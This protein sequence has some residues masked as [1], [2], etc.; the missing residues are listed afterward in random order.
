M[1]YLLNKCIPRD[2]FVFPPVSPWWIC[3]LVWGDV[4][5]SVHGAKCR[6]HLHS[7]QQTELKLGSKAL[8]WAPDACL[9][10]S[11]A[12]WHAVWIG[13]ISEWLSCSLLHTKA[14][15]K[16]ARSSLGT[17]ANKVKLLPEGAVRKQFLQAV[18]CSCLFSQ[19]YDPHCH[20]AAGHLA[21]LHTQIPSCFPTT[22]ISRTTWLVS[23][24]SSTFRLLMIIPVLLILPLILSACPL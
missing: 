23:L 9:L 19:S 5:H 4:W 17:M 14:K 18:L 20:P 6:A 11:S 15:L 10:T 2:S 16:A 22:D 12:I 13:N 8:A 21:V 24:L 1:I 7:N 3:L